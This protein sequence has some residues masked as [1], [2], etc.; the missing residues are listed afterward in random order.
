[1]DKTELKGFFR[2][3]DEATDKELQSKRSALLQLLSVLTEDA[4][5]DDARY[6]IR[7]IEEELLSREMRNGR[8][9]SARR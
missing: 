3:V 4:V 5:R 6:L 9:A 8:R 7:L 1:M 2:F